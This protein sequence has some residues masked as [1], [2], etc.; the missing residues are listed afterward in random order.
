[1]L[2]LFTLEIRTLRLVDGV[3]RI[4]LN[5]AVAEFGQMKVRY[6]LFVFI[7]EILCGSFVVPWS[8]FFVLL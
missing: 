2:D 6:F 3:S 1:M 7:P 4:F 5:P 8:I